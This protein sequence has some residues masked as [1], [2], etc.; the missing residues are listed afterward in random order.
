MNNSDAV[1]LTTKPNKIHLLNVN[2]YGWVS[3]RNNQINKITCKKRAS[4]NPRK[5]NVIIGSFGFSNK[6]PDANDFL[7]MK[8]LKYEALLIMFLIY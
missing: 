1:I 7:S 2:S 4:S 8:F 6:T 3:F 5:D